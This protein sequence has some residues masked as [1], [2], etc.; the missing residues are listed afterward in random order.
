MPF[1]EGLKI[2][3]SFNYDLRNQFQK[4]FQL[5]YYYYEYN[6]V[7]GEYDKKQG[8]GAST[9]ELTDRY[10]K[11]TTMLYNYRITYENTFNSHHI[12]AMVGQEQ[13]KNTYTWA[14]AYRKNFVS[15][16]IDQ[17]NVG[18]TAPEDKDNGGSA[19]EGAYNNYFG[20]LNY[21]YKSKYLLEFLF[22]YDGSQVF[23]KGKRYGFFPGVSVG[24]RLSEEDFFQ[25]SVSFVDQ[26]KL[27]ASYGEI[28][29]D[30][31]GSFQYLQ[32]YSFGN[33]Y[34]FG[35]ND[36]PGIYSN[37]LPNPNITWEVSKK[38]D[39]GLETSMWKGLLGIE[40]T[41]FKEKRSNIL[42]SRQ[43]SIPAILGFPGL[44]PE[45]IGKVDNHGFEL[46][47]RHR[48]SFNELKYTIEG[49]MSFA[50]SKIIYMDETPQA[51]PYQNQT[52]LPV[53]SFLIY[54]AD[55][56]FHTA[57]ELAAYP[58]VSGTQVGDIKILDLNGDNII[59]SKDQF[60]FDKSNTPEVVFG[61]NLGCNMGILTY[62]FSS[63][64]KPEFITMTVILEVWVLLILVMP[65]LKG[66]KTAGLL[67]IQMEPCHAQMH[68]N[69]EILLCTYL[70]L[71]S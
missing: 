6:T 47:L 18:S 67:I 46:T 9:V 44:P 38:T 1:V 57:E 54:K 41:Y 52:G 29:N 23:P 64:D 19:S 56:I 16:A 40:F 55:G 37:T 63:R 26:L 10:S 39:I 11:W 42:T 4:T 31:V 71:H 33:N 62:L 70:M 45:N 60:R 34:V 65:L 13:Q 5:P 14:S 36:V 21:D 35:G 27:R 43:L 61:L 30:R 7:S 66:Q 53:G 25:N 2:D 8:T 59:D 28:G 3:A 32:A 22:R 68:I 69:Q 58:H 51:E 50:R 17:I 20:R 12:T 24:W 15:P 48:N 49:N